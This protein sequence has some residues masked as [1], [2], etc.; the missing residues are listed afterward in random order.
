MMNLYDQIV[1]LY[2]TSAEWNYYDADIRK[3]FDK[4]KAREFIKQYFEYG[5]KKGVVLPLID[6]IDSLLDSSW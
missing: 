1:D 6:E 5:A 3:P 4:D 2:H